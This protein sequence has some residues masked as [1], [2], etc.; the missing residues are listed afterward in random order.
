MPFIVVRAPK[1]RNPIDNV[2]D[3]AKRCFEG[4]L[5]FLFFFFSKLR[6]L[7]CKR[8]RDSFARPSVII[9]C[10]TRPTRFY[11]RISCCLFRAAIAQLNTVLHTHTHCT[12]VYRLPN[13]YGPPGSNKDFFHQNSIPNVQK[14]KQFETG[15]IESGHD[16]GTK[17]QHD[18]NVQ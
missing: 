3:V 12:F 4:E 13:R 8:N 18:V 16:T 10:W 2:S 6:L 17:F 7:A 5:R 14:S 1:S 15:K 9:V 11:H